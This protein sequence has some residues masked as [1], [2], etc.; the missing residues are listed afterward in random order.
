MGEGRENFLH[1]FAAMDN[2]DT[3]DGDGEERKG[4]DGV[5]VVLLKTTGRAISPQELKFD[6][7]IRLSKI[8]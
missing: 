5:L 2:A 4:I 6:F 1:G 3:C 7:W 8:M